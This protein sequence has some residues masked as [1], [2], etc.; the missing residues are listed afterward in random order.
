MKLIIEYGESVFTNLRIASEIMLT[1]AASI[2]K[3]EWSFSCMKPILSNLRVSVSRGRLCDL[4]LMSV[5]FLGYQSRASKCKI[6]RV[7]ANFKI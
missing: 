4:A 5:N 3:C 7:R 1:T 6:W 2:V